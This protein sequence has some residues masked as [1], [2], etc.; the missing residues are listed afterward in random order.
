MSEH[1]LLNIYLERVLAG[2]TITKEEALSFYDFPLKDLTAAANDIREKMCGDGFAMCTI[3]NA[4]NGGCSE[5]CKFCAQSAAHLPQQA[6]PLL[7]TEVILADAKR[8]EAAG[9]PRYSLVTSGRRLSPREVEQVADTVQILKAETGL[10]ICGSF[11]LLDESSFRVL[12]AAGVDRIHNNLESSRDFFPNICT[13]HTFNDKIEALKAAK[14]AGM[15]ICSG[16][17]IGL[18]ESRADRI[19]M[20]FT[21]RNLEVPSVPINVLNPIPNTPL[22]NRGVLPYEEVLKTIAIFR[23]ILPKALLR[24]AG[25]RALFPDGGRAAFQAG[26]NATI[27]GDMLTTAGISAQTDLTLIKELHFRLLPS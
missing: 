12:F 18:G 22:G 13:S 15:S 20:A 2:D 23:F 6:E 26:A 1:Q 11:G 14:S 19:D 4:K 21:L 9:I 27:T 25:G 8:Q 24:L 16:G 17:I 3:I 5:N 10:K 7:H